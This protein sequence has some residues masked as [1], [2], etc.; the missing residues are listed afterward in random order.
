MGARVRVKQEL[1]R[2]EAVPFLRGVGTVNAIAVDLAGADAANP[3]MKD[4]V[5][6]FGQLYPSDLFA[7]LGIEEA[8]FNLCCMS[9]EE[10]EVHPLPSPGRTQR[11]RQAFAKARFQT[12][13][14]GPLQPVM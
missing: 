5:G 10:R 4:L 11:M 6:I 3:A 2:V 8:E 13:G 14:Q 9:G 12:V 7:A 1:V